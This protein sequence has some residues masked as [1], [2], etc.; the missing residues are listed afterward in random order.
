M[1]YQEC[2]QLSSKVPVLVLQLPPMPA[3]SIE[4]NLYINNGESIDAQSPPVRVTGT[5]HG[6]RVTGEI[7]LTP[8]LNQRVDFEIKV[9][10]KKFPDG[11]KVLCKDT[12]LNMDIEVRLLPT[13]AKKNEI[14]C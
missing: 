7:S 10:D 6:F 13:T 12:E 2:C 5:K 14:F 9:G 3:Y 1:I 8:N 11:L 4:S